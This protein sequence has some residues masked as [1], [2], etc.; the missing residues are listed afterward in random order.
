MQQSRGYQL[1]IR[2]WQR[3]SRRRALTR[4]DTTTRA[5]TRATRE[6]NHPHG[7]R[8]E[9]GV[10]A[11]RRGCLHAASHE[12]RTPD[13]RGGRGTC[14]CRANHT[15]PHRNHARAPARSKHTHSAERRPERP[16]DTKATTWAPPGYVLHAESG[17][18]RGN[19]AKCAAHVIAAGR[20]LPGRRPRSSSL[21]PDTQHNTC[22][23]LHA[24]L[25]ERR[26]SRASR[27]T[28]GNSRAA[29]GRMACGSSCSGTDVATSHT[30]G[31][32]P[33]GQ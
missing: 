4:T 23:R 5:R 11:A 9:R 25:A 31:T 22:S 33:A 18:T 8:R 21:R 13:S 15:L 1:Y 30:R 10:H 28:C 19:H 17:S 32:P 3:G 2:E 7:T 20:G 16:R 24:Q 12:T 29:V 26:A 6:K 14:L 27:R